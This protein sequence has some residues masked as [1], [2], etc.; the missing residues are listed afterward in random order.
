MSERVFINLSA[1]GGSGKVVVNVYSDNAMLPSKL[2][3]PLKRAVEEN[4]R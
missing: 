4:S 3:G 1:D 2:T